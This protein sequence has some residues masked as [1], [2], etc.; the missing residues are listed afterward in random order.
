MDTS[1]TSGI[2]RIEL[3]DDGMVNRG[4]VTP[5]TPGGRSS[6]IRMGDLFVVHSGDDYRPAAVVAKGE[7]WIDVSKVHTYSSDD[8]F[9]YLLTDSEHDVK[10]PGKT[11]G[12]MLEIMVREITFSR[13]SQ[14]PKKDGDRPSRRRRHGGRSRSQRHRSNGN[15]ATATISEKLQSNALS[16]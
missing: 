13:R 16:S 8:D 10:I 14:A 3:K 5:L 11:E 15:V 2:I 12:W 7:G 9:L 6:P 4:R 1:I